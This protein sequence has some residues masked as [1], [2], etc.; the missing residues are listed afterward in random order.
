MQNCSPLEYCNVWQY[1]RNQS[2]QS[3]AQQIWLRNMRGAPGLDLIC[4]QTKALQWGQLRNIDK[5]A[6]KKKMDKIDRIHVTIYC[7]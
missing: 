4:G 6:S 5:N 3:V 1:V 7:H 2:L